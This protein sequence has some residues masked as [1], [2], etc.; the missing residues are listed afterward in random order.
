MAKKIF[1]SILF[2]F[3]I[4]GIIILPV[5]LEKDMNLKIRKPAVSGT[6]YPSSQ[7][8]LTSQLEGFFKDTEIEYSGEIIN[9]LIAPHAGYIYSGKT[10]MFGYK[11]LYMDLI[12]RKEDSFKVIILAPNHTEYTNKI[13]IPDYNSFRTPLGD[14][15]LN[16]TKIKAEINNSPH[17][18]EHAI[19]VQLPFLQYIFKKANKEFTIIPIIVGDVNA[20]EIKALAKDI[21]SEITENT[22]IIV[23]SDLSHYQPQEKA[24]EIDNKTIHNILDRKTTA[25]LDACGSNPIKVLEEISILR[26][27]K[28]PKLLNYS[29]SG[30]VTRDKKAVVGYASISF[31]KEKEHLLLRL[32]HRTIQNAFDARKENFFDLEQSVPKEYLERKGSFVTLTINKRLRGCIGNIK[33]T[34]TVFQGI[35][36]NSK[37]AAFQDPR[38]DSLT[39]KEFEKVDIEISLLSKPV[40]CNLSDIKK[41]DGVIIR[42]GLATAVYLPQVWEQLPDKDSFLASLCEKAGLEWNC[43]KEKATKF[44]RFEVE[45]IE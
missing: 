1:F 38:F 33:G 34:K 41:G 11:Q 18:Q 40:D 5:F 28:E 39:E 24:Q 17:E 23:S 10:A 37:F 45:I 44:Q 27:W 7:L 31:T 3:I 21:N 29:T 20:E 6:F 25:S 14:I 30:D 22:I 35:I 12:L 43:Y 15:K 42:Q 36:D 4:F 13:I 16:S 8:A 19:E 2:S 9:A 26:S 32:A